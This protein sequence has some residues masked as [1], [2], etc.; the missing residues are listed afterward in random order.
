MR[1]Y[2]F[3]ASSQHRLGILWD[4]SDPV[5]RR[6][7][8]LWVGK[9]FGINMA[10]NI[11]L[12]NCLCAVTGGRLI[13]WEPS[14]WWPVG[15]PGR[16][17]NW[18]QWNPYTCTLQPPHILSCSLSHLLLL[19]H[20]LPIG[21]IYQRWPTTHYYIPW[22]QKYWGVLLL[23][24]IHLGR[25]PRWGMEREGRRPVTPSH[26]YY[27]IARNLRRWNEGGPL[28]LRG[29]YFFQRWRRH[30]WCL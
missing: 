26:K 2:E 13:P 8:V 20:V 15:N 6:W 24:P 29:G 28:W 22:L 18:L 25:P 30:P 10:W 1:Y 9:D 3:E 7:V 17:C 14:P 21:P 16:C 11:P 19:D 4:L 5:V 12:N 27:L 23:N